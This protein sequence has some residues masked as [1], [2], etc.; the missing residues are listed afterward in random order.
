MRTLNENQFH[1]VMGV[2]LF[3][4]LFLDRIATRI[5]PTWDAPQVGLIPFALGLVWIGRFAA[6]RGAK[7]RE[8]VRVLEDRIQ[9][10][11]R[12][13]NAFEDEERARR[14]PPI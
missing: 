1:A 13:L 12:R 11:E 6:W 7:D 3:G 14:R 2:L 9:R 10:L 8:P 4:S 5:I